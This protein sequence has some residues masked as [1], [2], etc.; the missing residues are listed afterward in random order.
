MQKHLGNRKSEIIDKKQKKVRQ[1]EQLTKKHRNE[2]EDTA[3]VKKEMR[4]DSSK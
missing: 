4:K 2:C 3:A 1:I